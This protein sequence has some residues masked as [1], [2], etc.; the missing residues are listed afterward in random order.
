[1][2]LSR[3]TPSSSSTLKGVLQTIKKD[4][5]EDVKAVSTT[6]SSAIRGKKYEC[7]CMKDAQGIVNYL[8]EI[9]DG[10]SQQLFVNAVGHLTTEDAINECRA[11]LKPDIKGQKRK[12]GSNEEK[13]EAVIK[14]MVK[15]IG[16]LDNH[17][18]EVNELKSAVVVGAMKHYVN[19]SMRKKVCDNST[20]DSML[21]HR[22]TQIKSSSSND[23]DELSKLMGKA[24]L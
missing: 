4:K 12:Y 21:E 5:K 10:Q 16:D 24:H 2:G 13:A 8:A 1:M 7:C 14:K 15:V 9:P 19:F 17:I 11:I 23:L 20:L 3:D 6:L 18:E 22:L